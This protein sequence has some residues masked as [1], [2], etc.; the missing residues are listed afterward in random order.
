M[1]VVDIKGIKAKPGE[2]SLGFLDVGTTS[3]NTYRIPV[4]VINGTEEGKTLC[5]IGGTH[6]TEFASIEAVI[7]IVQ[8]LNPKE[9]KGTVLAVTVLNGPQFEHRSAFL[10]PFDQLNQ[11]RQFPGNPEGT[12]SQRTAHVVFSE[13]VSKADA[14]IDC[15]G[16]DI[17]EDIDDMVIVQLGPN[18]EA[19][20]TAAEMASCFPTKYVVTHK[21]GEIGGSSGV[22]TEKYGIPCIT[23][24]AGT[25]YPVRERHVRFH[26]DGIMNNLKYFGIIPGKP[27]MVQPTMNPVRYRF[28]TNLGGIW[29][30]YVDLAQMVSKGQEVGNISDLFGNIIETYKVPEDS[31]VTFLRVFYSVNVGEPLIGLVVLK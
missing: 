2:K 25:P 1:S 12:L 20:K 14:L 18:K 8:N 17:T 29:H 26:Y 4:A 5:L 6:G 3:V 24:E 11:N 15:H 13:M 28:K 21:P 9:M 30:P 22:A 23:S 19:N 10:S 31:M 16:G 27:Q 7:R